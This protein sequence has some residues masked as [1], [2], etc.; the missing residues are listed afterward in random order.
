MENSPS[1]GNNSLLISVIL[2]I[3]SWFTPERVD[4]GL[5]VATA[6]GAVTAAIFAARYH[7]YATKEKKARIKRLLE[8]YKKEDED[9]KDDI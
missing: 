4:I 8:R 1:N 5:K 6:F 2:G 3:F 9:D 7:Y